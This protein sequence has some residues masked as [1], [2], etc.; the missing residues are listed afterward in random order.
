MSRVR[1][2]AIE[3]VFALVKKLQAETLA[4]SDVL[5]NDPEFTQLERNAHVGLLC[6]DAL[7]RISE[8]VQSFIPDEDPEL[9]IKRQCAWFR[10]AH[11]L[12][13]KYPRFVP[14][15]GSSRHVSEDACQYLIQFFLEHGLGWFTGIGTIEAIDHMVEEAASNG[16][17]DHDDPELTLELMRKHNVEIVGNSDVTYG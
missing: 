4:K 14:Y 5:H 6:A 1:V 11:L 10:A 8:K 13:G 17:F 12:T 15:R 2:S 7:A 16:N 9:V 3:E